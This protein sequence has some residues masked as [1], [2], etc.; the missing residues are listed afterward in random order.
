MTDIFTPQIKVEPIY[1]NPNAPFADDRLY[2][3]N[4]P[5][6]LET[7]IRTWAQQMFGDSHIEISRIKLR[8]KMTK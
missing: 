7:D 6:D 8:V 2:E 3:I 4:L 5:A 1:M